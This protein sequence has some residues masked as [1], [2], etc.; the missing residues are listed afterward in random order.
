MKGVGL[1]R[2]MRGSRYALTPNVSPARVE[3]VA[4]EYAARQDADRAKLERMSLYAQSAN[5]RWKLLLDYF[6]E[7]EGFERCDACDNC[8]EPLEQRI[9]RPASTAQGLK[10]DG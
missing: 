1:V 2:E 3:S 10:L 4:R 7:A 9:A 8:L 5:C 6:G